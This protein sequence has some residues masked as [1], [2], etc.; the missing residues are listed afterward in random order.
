GYV[1]EKPIIFTKRQQECLSKALSVSEQYI[2]LIKEGK[3]LDNCSEILSDIKQNLL[4][5]VGISCFS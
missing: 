4:N 1:P 5:C 2:H 3:D